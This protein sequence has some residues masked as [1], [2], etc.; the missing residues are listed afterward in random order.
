LLQK[1]TS[2][3]P[4]KRLQP[5]L[6]YETTDAELE[7]STRLDVEKWMASIKKTP[8]PKK[9]IEDLE[10]E[11]KMLRCLTEPKKPMSLDYKYTM[12][13]P[14]CAKRSDEILENEDEQMSKFYLE[15]GSS[16]EQLHGQSKMQM[17]YAS[18]A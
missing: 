7:A 1:K 2:S 15:A 10:A 9:S 17:A 11:V 6:S 14:H 5:L 13:N 8:T 16:L 12:M 3:S 4:F 18:K